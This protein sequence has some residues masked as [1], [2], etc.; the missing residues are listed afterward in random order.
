MPDI[1]ELGDIIYSSLTKENVIYRKSVFSDISNYCND[2]VGEIKNEVYCNLTK[3]TDCLL[4]RHKIAAI[5]IIAVLKKKLFT[6]NA[7]PSNT[8]FI[9]M[10]AN[11]HYAL[12][13]LKAILMGW[14]EYNGDDVDIDMPTAYKDNLLLL[15]NKY[16]K[17][18]SA[19]IIDNIF[20]YALAN[21]VYLVE[22]RF[23]KQPT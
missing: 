4:D 8:T 18:Q 12:L 10:L 3:T 23:L 19:P 15:F 6:T 7:Q 11:E 9:D 22:E 20:V 17:T 1:E 5:H 21:I 16:I 13:L 14:H 2:K